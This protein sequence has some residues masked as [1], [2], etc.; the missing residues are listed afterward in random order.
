MKRARRLGLV[1]ASILF[2][3]VC[4]VRFAQD[5][6]LRRSAARFAAAAGLDSDRPGGAV[7]VSV[8]PAGDLAAG[9]TV[10]A[11][12]GQPGSRVSGKVRAGALALMLDAAAVRPGWADHRFWI[13]LSDAAGERSRRVLRLAAGA[14]PGRSDLWA[15]L[16][17]ADLAAWP[18]LSAAA[19]SESVEVLGQAMKSEEFVSSEYATIEAALG[20]GRARSLLPE[21]AGV[22]SAAAGSLAE[23]S[24]LPGAADLLA[25][26]DVAERRDRGRD[27][28]E[29]ERHRRLEDVEGSRRR[30]RAWFE[31]HPF[32]EQDDA[33]GRRQLARLL[34]LWPD[35]RFGSWSRDPRARL[36]R[37]F[38]DGRLSDVPAETLLRTLD[39]LT[40]V[41]D[42]VR[43]RVLLAAGR[44]A[45]AQALARGA[46]VS[47]DWDAYFLDLSRRQLAAGDVS[48]ASAALTRLSL[49]A[50]DGCEALLARRGVARALEDVI[51][52]SAIEARLAPMRDPPPEDLASRGSL[53]ICVDP[54]WSRGRFLEVVAAPGHS[55]LLAWGWNGGRAATLLLPAEGGSFVVPLDSFS[56]RRTLWASFLAG[57]ASRSLHPL[58]KTAS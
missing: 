11:V 27:L 56:G 18:A 4:L 26:A 58:L 38:L 3:G 8:E 10:S 23:R 24:D 5:R 7:K 29:I 47:N 1:A 33:E 43:A 51:G 41:P 32:S 21:D 6:S 14:A 25:R 45:P 57:D 17:R 46:I 42:A 15:T 36:A 40:G 35:D 52:A 12:L 22:L 9:L 31:E 53:P 44:L 19:R 28:D 30:C 37:F 49:G 13:G 39:L 20:S 48:E 55:A 54:E 50:R 16:A 34:A 2:A